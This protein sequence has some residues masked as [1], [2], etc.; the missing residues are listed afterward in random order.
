MKK[1]KQTQ[2]HLSIRALAR[3]TGL[4]ART[5][6]KRLSWGCGEDSYDEDRRPTLRAFVADLDEDEA[7]KVLAFQLRNLAQKSAKL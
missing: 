4:D 6:A 1:T 2:E 5:V 7:R 3:A